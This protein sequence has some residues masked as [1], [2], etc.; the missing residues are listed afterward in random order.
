MTGSIASASKVLET[1]IRLTEARSRRA[2][3]HARATASS[4]GP[5]G[6]WSVKDDEVSVVMVAFIRFSY[7][8]FVCRARG[9]GD[10]SI[11]TESA[12]GF[13]NPCR[14]AEFRGGN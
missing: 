11:F 6:K 14:Y 4:T 7:G 8:R 3:L 9:F 13:L 12:D 1:A 5:V 2:S 10:S